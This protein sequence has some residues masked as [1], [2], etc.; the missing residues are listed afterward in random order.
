MN[1]SNFAHA[2]LAIIFTVIIYLLFGN[3]WIGTAFAIGVFAGRE[4]THREFEISKPHLLWGHEALDFWRW[5]LDNKLDLI[6]PTIAAIATSILINSKYNTILTT[7][8]V[9]FFK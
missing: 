5:S 8:M 9:N 6:F 3:P 2:F 1:S 4:H 7:T